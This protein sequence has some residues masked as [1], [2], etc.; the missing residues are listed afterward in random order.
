MAEIA[1]VKAAEAAKQYFV[2]SSQS[3]YCL[4]EVAEAAP[5]GKLLFE[6]DLRLNLLV[7]QDLIKRLSK[8]SQFKGIVM[9]ASYQSCRVTENEWKNDF[10]L[11]KHLNAGNLLRYKGLYGKNHLIRDGYGLLSNIGK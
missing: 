3:S 5:N 11:P 1:S 10:Q 7:Q 9:N 8:Y 4:E 6:M 2:L